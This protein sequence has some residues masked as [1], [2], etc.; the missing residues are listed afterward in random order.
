MRRL[1][2]S[3]RFRLTAAVIIPLAALILFFGVVTLWVA[4]NNE[5]DTVDRVLIGSV[6]TLSLAYN[7]PA[8]DR[9][10][11][12]P[13]AVHLLK[14]RAR[15]VVHY[16]VW[17]GDRL[18]AGD[19]ALRPPVDYS[20]TWDGRVDPHPPTTFVNAYRQTS[21]LRGYLEP[22][23]ARDVT[24]AA[25]LRDGILHGKSARIAVEIRRAHGDDRLIAIQ[26]ADY[27]DDRLAHERANMRRI[28]LIGTV[29]LIVT[30]LLF[31]LAIR[32]GL[33][34]LVVL[35]EQVEAAR[36]EASPAIRLDADDATPTEIRPFVIAFNGL[37]ARLERASESLRQF[38]SNA[39]HQMRTPLAVVQVHLDVLDR[40]GPN[41]P[42]GKA[43]L[44]D[45][46]QAIDTLEQLLRQL[47]A[48]AR[49]EDQLAIPMQPFDLADVVAGVTGERA[50]QAS[51]D[52]T[53]SY[54]GY[55]DGPV[56]AMG[57]PSLAVELIGNL[58]D[59][60]I[61]Y[62]RPAGTVSVRVIGGAGGPRLEIDDDGPGIP[63]HEREKVW[64]RFYRISG[65][66]KAAGTGLGLP[67][68]LALAQ[69]MG[70]TIELADGRTGS[71][72]CVTVCFRRSG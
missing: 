71:G 7:S 13:L 16:S 42:Q 46:P 49:S 15:P 51:A 5:A 23:D 32:W 29:A 38:T 54:E 45:I 21:L 8:A 27:A 72:L 10:R 47:I 40:Y 69:R 59:N 60:A 4:Q 52:M 50:A 48:L 6:R 24:Q 39:S 31:W 36:R 55:G 12:V 67:I 57:Q 11:L 61:R 9:E 1:P 37:M 20:A 2:Q 14:R 70:A 66:G 63:E 22:A 26:I 17:R 30:G 41:S 28:L 43:A 64:D 65:R 44:T 19:A 53:I 34:P 35:T 33:R 3:L 56:I 58:L 68:A 25:Y 18:V 62:S